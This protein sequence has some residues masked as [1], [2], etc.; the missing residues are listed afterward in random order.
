MTLT[1]HIDALRARLVEQHGDQLDAITAGIL[2]NLE[3]FADEI[4]ELLR[5]ARSDLAQLQREYF[6]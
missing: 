6:A 2:N 4:C 1:D 5:D 3:E